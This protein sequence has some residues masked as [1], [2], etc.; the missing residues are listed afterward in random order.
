MA[1]EQDARSL[2]MPASDAA[3]SPRPAAA[4]APPGAGERLRALRSLV[5]TETD[6]NARR[7]LASEVPVVVRPFAAAAASRLRELRA[8]CELARHLHRARHEV[9]PNRQPIAR[10]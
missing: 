9:S 5:V 7:R 6:A 4:L 2:P 1:S 10:K 8:L 3:T